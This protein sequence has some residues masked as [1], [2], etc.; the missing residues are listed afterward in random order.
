M[1]GD[2]RRAAIALSSSGPGTSVVRYSLCVV[3]LVRCDARLQ[4]TARMSVATASPSKTEKFS[5]GQR[6]WARPLAGINCRSSSPPPDGRNIPA[7]DIARSGV[8]ELAPAAQDVRY[9]ACY[10]RF[11]SAGIGRKCEF[12][13]CRRAWMVEVLLTDRRRHSSDQ[14]QRRRLRF[15]KEL[16]KHMPAVMAISD[17]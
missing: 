14:T 3:V 16:S 6:S 13:G 5:P 2:G 8:E 10:D 12:F 17:R 9:S 15:R 11:P 1:M 7:A 4:R